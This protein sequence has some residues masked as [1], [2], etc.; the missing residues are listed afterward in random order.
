M[1]VIIASILARDGNAIDIGAHSGR[2][3]R[4]ILRV[5][6]AGRHIAYEPLPHLADYLRSEFPGVEVHNA[7]VSD[8]N[9]E[10]SFVFVESAPEYSGLRERTY[11]SYEQSPRTKLTVRA[12]R[13][14]DALPDGY[15][16][17]LIKIDVEGAELL[18][19]RGALETLRA[20]RPAIIFEHG[21]GGPEAY[22]Y[23]PGEVHDLLVGELGMRIFDLD[24]VGP[25]SRTRFIEVFPEPVWNFLAVS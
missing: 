18:V 13:L 24:G 19:L 2:I 9:G 12:E 20:H 21:I 8:A 16:P 15:R 11:G 17:D 14:D 7:A 22:G 25:Y 1:N 10:V 4:E 6:P 23:G 3:L 5:A